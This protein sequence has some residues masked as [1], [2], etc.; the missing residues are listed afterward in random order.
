VLPLTPTGPQIDLNEMFGPRLPNEIYYYLSQGMISPNVLN[1][2]IGGFVE[3]HPLCSGDAPGY[4]DFITS[5][6]V[7]IWR[8]NAT[9]LLLKYLNRG[10]NSPKC[11]YWFEGISGE[12]YDV[13]RG[14][15]GVGN[16]EK[17]SK[18]MPLGKTASWINESRKRLKVDG[19]ADVRFAIESTGVLDKVANV[20]PLDVGLP[21]V[22]PTSAFQIAS[23]VFVRV[24]EVIGYVKTGATGETKVQA[25]GAAL[26]AG[27]GKKRGGHEGLVT[28]IELLLCGG[29]SVKSGSGSGDHISLIT[30]VMSM[31]GLEGVSGTVAIP[32]G[33]SKSL[34]EFNSFV[35]VWAGN[36]M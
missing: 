16:W 19:N 24:A 26:L 25:P 13:G 9:G 33:Y 1:S 6:R 14:G 18:R 29:I 27:G 22:W 20:A 10:I 12:G 23:L 32:V 3:G 36:L 15:S 5:D 2:L 8:G 4:R 7:A 21:I 28:F 35:K 17:G 31:I 11:M 34:L 30:R